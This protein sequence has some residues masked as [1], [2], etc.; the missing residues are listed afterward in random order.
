[1]SVIRGTRNSRKTTQEFASTKRTKIIDT[2]LEESMN[3]TKQLSHFQKHALI[4]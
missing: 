4:D 3:Q 1:M 2:I